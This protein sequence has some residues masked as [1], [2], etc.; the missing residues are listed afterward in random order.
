MSE[1]A[2]KLSLI[3]LS[4]LLFIFQFI[5]WD[6]IDVKLNFDIDIMNIFY[7]YKERKVKQRKVQ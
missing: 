4:L 7:Q 1:K 5:F 2:S 3:L 6:Y